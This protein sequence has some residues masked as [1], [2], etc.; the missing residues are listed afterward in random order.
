MKRRALGLLLAAALT[1]GLLSGCQ[2]P[3]APEPEAPA[4]EETEEPAAEEPEAP[5]A[6]AEESEA[7]ADDGTA[8]YA[9]LTLTEE[10]KAAVKGKTIGVSYCLLSAPA[11]KVFAQGI[12]EEAKELGITLVELD[13]NYDPTTQ[14]SQMSELI[15]QKVDA[16]VLNPC[17]GTSLVASA[18]EAYDAGIPVVTGAMNIDESGAEYIV[19]FVGA[20]D[21]DVGF[22]AGE[23][24]KSH[25]ESG[26]V[27][28]I[29]GTAGSSAQVNRTAGFERSL[30]GSNLEIVA[31]LSADFDEAKAM[32]VMQDLLTRY[33]DLKGVF[34]QDDTMASGAAQA[35]KELSYTGEDVA[36][37]GYNG[38]AAGAKLIEEGYMIASAVQPLVEEGRGSIRALVKAMNGEE[39]NPWYKDVIVPLDAETLKTYDESL[40]W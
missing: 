27:A 18:K 2:K 4:Q 29:E 26:Q 11:V 3:S 5:E 9:D 15:A 32:D 31:K 16:I 6:E 20:D 14:A 12:Q 13:G 23:A 17:D 40:L 37:V 7:P 24:M 28:I 30:E 35:M 36:L 8:T 34:C 10:E 22:C 38:S 19:S 21:E 39:V 33:P 1:A 25:V